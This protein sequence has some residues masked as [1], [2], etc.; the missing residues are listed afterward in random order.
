MAFLITWK[1]VDLL[2]R[3]GQNSTYLDPQYA[4]YDVPSTIAIGVVHLCNVWLSETTYYVILF[5]F[6]TTFN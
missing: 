5:Q 2:L 4:I 3:R 6:Y 1:G